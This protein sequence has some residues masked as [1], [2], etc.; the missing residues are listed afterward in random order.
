MVRYAFVMLLMLMMLISVPLPGRAQE[1]SP[2]PTAA[3]ATP[4]S[5]S[6]EITT[7][8]LV[9]IR[10]PA[11]VIPPPPTS[12]DV[13]QWILRRGEELTYAGDQPSIA[14]DVVLS[15]EYSVQ[16]EGRIQVQRAAGLEEVPPGTE[17]TVRPGDAVIYVENQ[18]TQILRNSGDE[19]AR[20][21]SV[22]VFSA[23]PPADGPASNV[24]SSRVSPEDWERSGLAGQNLAVSV[25]RL[26]VPPGASLPAFVPDVQA[27]RIFSVARG[28]AEWTI[29]APGAATPP[30]AEPFVRNEVLWFRTLG[31][32]EQLQLQNLGDRPLVLLQ[33]TLSADHAA[34]PIATPLL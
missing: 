30:P 29:I 17:V 9:R 23:D 28:A 24:A 16:S 14:A 13:W 1:A 27:P 19:V 25:E 26:T 22:E 8:A 33:V 4:V 20:V 32:G 11:A 34:M 15:G 21:I 12:V 10:L 18:A 6:T 2:I 5:P 31:E 7:E 3:I